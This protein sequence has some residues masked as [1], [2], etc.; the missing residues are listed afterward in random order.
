MWIKEQSTLQTMVQSWERIGLFQDEEHKF[1]Y[2][3]ELDLEGT[4]D[5]DGIDCLDFNHE[6]EIHEL[7][8]EEEVE[9][10]YADIN[11]IEVKVE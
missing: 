10:L 11:S 5:G 6:I 1:D 3:E 2:D 7:S 9:N 4:D 8:E